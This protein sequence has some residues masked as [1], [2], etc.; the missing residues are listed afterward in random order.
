[1]ATNYPT[2]LDSYTTLVDNVDDVLA[3]HANDRGDAIV[4][5][6][7]KI[8]VDSSAVTTSFDYFLKHASGAYRNHTHDGTSDDGPN[9][10]LANT[11]GTLAV[12]R[13]GTGQTTASAAFDA[14]SPMTTLGDTVYG[15]TSGTGTRLPGNTTATKKFM[16]QTGTGSVSAA[17]SWG[18]I[19]AS[20]L[21]AIT[22]SLLPSGVIV[23]Q[24]CTIDQ[25][26]R[27]VAVSSG[28]PSDNTKPQWSEGAEYT[29]LATSFTPTKTSNILIIELGIS[30]ETSNGNG[31]LLTGTIFDTPSV[32]TDLAIAADALYHNS[33][34][35]GGSSIQD[36]RL[37]AIAK[38]TVGSLTTKTFK[39]RVSQ[40]AGTGTC[41]LNQNGTAAF[42][43][44]NLFSS[45]LRITEI[46]V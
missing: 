12:N 11:T 6:E 46:Q 10:P 31:G 15:G 5:L 13:G 37:Y 42:N 28:I 38:L 18:T 30:G 35:L 23:Q 17:P 21:P 40:G 4:A 32:S 16:T 25:T 20:D 44:G 33:T 8:G 27:S 9:V 36:G 1:M 39:V 19:V 3:A 26:A 34:N 45:F 2:S 43:Y 41:L 14:L 29:Q 7:T 22:A 24:V